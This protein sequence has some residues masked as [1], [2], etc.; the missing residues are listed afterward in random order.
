MLREK[1][2]SGES[3]A[4]V[5]AQPCRRRRK[6]DLHHKGQDPAEAAAPVELT[7]QQGKHRRWLSLQFAYRLLPVAACKFLSKPER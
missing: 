7:L 6:R 3:R 5:D 1:A 4:S 2:N